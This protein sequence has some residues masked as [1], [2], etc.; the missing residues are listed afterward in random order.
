S[1]AARA[2]ENT[3]EAVGCA[4]AVLV[5]IA[6]ATERLPTR[7]AAAHAAG[8]S[9]ATPQQV[10]SAV[11]DAER[12]VAGAE[13]I[14]EVRDGRVALQPFPDEQVTRIRRAILHLQGALARGVRL[15]TGRPWCRPAARRRVARFACRAGIGRAGHAHGVVAD[16]TDGARVP[17]VAR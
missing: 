8:R 6:L 13:R 4:S 1:T 5:A 9:F 12:L 15:P 17:V 7:R 3:R 11:P 16:V 2:E 10:L 14:A